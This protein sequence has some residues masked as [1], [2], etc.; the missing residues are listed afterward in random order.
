MAATASAAD[1]DDDDDANPLDA[2][3]NDF[4]VTAGEKGQVKIWNAKSLAL[5][6]THALPSHQTASEVSAQAV[7]SEQKVVSPARLLLLQ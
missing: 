3:A 6:H 1:S 4:F 5:V 7:G 2:L